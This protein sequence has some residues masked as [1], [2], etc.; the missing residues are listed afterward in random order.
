MTYNKEHIQ[1]LLIEKAAGTISKGD[2]DFIEQAI[3]NDSDIDKMWKEVQQKLDSSK[4]RAFLINLNEDEAWDNIER[5][6]Q[7][8]PVVNMHHIYLKRWMSIAALFCI[9]LASIYYF[10]TKQAYTRVAVKADIKKAVELQFV[11]G[12]TIDLSNAGKGDINTPFARLYTENKTLSY[13]IVNSKGQEWGTLNVP[14]IL[15]YKIVLSDGTQVWLNASSVLHFPFTFP[16][17]TREVYLKGEAF[18]KVAKNA[19]KPFIVHTDQTDI[20]VLGTSFNINTYTPEVITTSLVEGS[21]STNDYHKEKLLLKP[22]FQAIY[23]PAKGFVTQSFDESIELGWMKG[24]YYFHDTKLSD[25]TQVLSR[26]FDVKVVFD[27]PLKAR[28]SF[29]GQLAKNKPL[30]VFLLNLKTSAEI[31]TYFIDGTLHI[32]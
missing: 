19:K 29:S 31:E 16:G 8:I 1:D 20:R 22:G 5:K 26:W 28:E 10:R 13:N 27:N 18:F 14:S 2:N 6:I 11:N 9:T 32:K 7:H 25:I 4:A 12:Q 24:V 17:G 23:T 21:V 15:D 30:T 3:E